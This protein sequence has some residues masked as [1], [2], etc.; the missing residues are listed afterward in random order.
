MRVLITGGSGL[1]GR[2]LTKRLVAHEHEVVILSRS[3]ERVTGLPAGA[4]A[5]GWDAATA[6]GWAHEADG[7]G[8]I[9]NLAGANLGAGRWTEAR[10]QVSLESRLRATQAVVEAITSADTPPPVLVQGSAVGRYGDSGDQ[11]LTED[12]TPAPSSDDF[13]ALVVREWEAASAPVEA[14]GVRRVIARTGVVLDDDEGALPRLA[15]PVRFFVGGPVGGG[16]QWVPWIHRADEASALHFLIEHADA[17]GA[18]NLAAPESATN[19]QLTR[20][21]GRALGRPTV[22]PV[23]GFAIRLLLGEQAQVVLDSLRAVPARLTAAGW[24]PRFGDLD[25]AVRDLL[26]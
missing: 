8:A 9:V 2:A 21:V 3:P 1:I 18:Y 23:P 17:S 20:A 13:L 19:A 7:A 14:A 10:K 26:G 5:I 25:E 4:R 24:T 22:M 11:V 12:V 16:K 6:D 15:M